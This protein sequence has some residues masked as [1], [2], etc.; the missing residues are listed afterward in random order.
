MLTDSAIMQAMESGEI[1]ISPFNRKNLGANSYDITIAPEVR[2][3]NKMNSC[4]VSLKHEYSNYSDFKL[5]FT[6][7]PREMLLF[8]SKERLGCL[9]RTCGI[10]SPRSNLSRSGLIFQF[11]HLLDT[12][13]NGIISGSI[14]NAAPHAITIPENL[15]IAQIMFHNIEGELLEA[16]NERKWSKN[17][18]QTGIE[19]IFYRPDKEWLE[20]ENQT[21]LLGENHEAE[22]R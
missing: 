13:F 14:L 11:S 18:G 19:N 21:T 3:I 6:I 2:R 9:R 7:L 15:R 12:G 5:P 22:N 1:V 17:I 10:I 16:Y 20:G 4:I 8:A